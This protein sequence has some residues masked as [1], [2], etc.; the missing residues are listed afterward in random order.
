MSH[1]KYTEWLEKVE[2][3]IHQHALPS[4]HDGY[5]EL[6]VVKITLEAGPYF[7]HQDGV[8]LDQFRSFISTLPIYLY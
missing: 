8:F 7:S 4:P 6:R 5:F 3:R 2:I 1:Y